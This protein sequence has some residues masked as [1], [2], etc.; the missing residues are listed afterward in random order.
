MA[1]S[2]ENYAFL[3]SIFR[4]ISTFSAICFSMVLK[5]IKN[6]SDCFYIDPTKHFGEFF[7]RKRYS[8]RPNFMLA[9]LL[10]GSSFVMNPKEKYAYSIAVI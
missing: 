8:G 4:V 3:P 9:P 5:P 10:L 2:F 6:W 7:S 1:I